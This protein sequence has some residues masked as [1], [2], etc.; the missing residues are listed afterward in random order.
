MLRQQEAEIEELE[1]AAKEV[2]RARRRQEAIDRG[3][4]PDEIVFT[5]EDE[6][7]EDGEGGGGGGGAGEGGQVDKGMEQ[8]RKKRNAG[9]P[10]HMVLYCA[11][12]NESFKHGLSLSL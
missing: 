8:V 2:E 11:G 6:E 9:T 5:S 12:Q 1:R 7:G 4:D 3:E 10:F